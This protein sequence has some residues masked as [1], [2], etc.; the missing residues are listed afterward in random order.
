LKSNDF[1]KW[2]C[3][4]LLKYLG[5]FNGK[6]IIGIATDRTTHSA[7]AVR[8]FLG[9]GFEYIESSNTTIGEMSTFLA[10]LSLLESLDPNEITFRAHTKGVTRYGGEYKHIEQ[11][12]QMLYDSCLGDIA[13]VES[14]LVSKVMT[15]ECRRIH[16]L[17][18]GFWF[19]AGSFYWFRHHWLFSRDWRDIQD[20]A[21]WGAENFPGIMC[22]KEETDFLAVDNCPHPYKVNQFRKILRAYN[23]QKASL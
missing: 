16:R 10:T 4:N 18:R 15:G 9:D 1:W 6:K 2:N 21:R 12:A 8:R 3:E 5:V 23:Q 17:G 22:K 13:K 19:Y 20:T 7:D 11:W 14:Q